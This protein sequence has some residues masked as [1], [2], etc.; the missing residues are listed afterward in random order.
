[1]VGK[2]QLLTETSEPEEE[3]F[4]AT[5]NITEGQSAEFCASSFIIHGG[6]THLLSRA[7]KKNGFNGSDYDPGFGI[8][9]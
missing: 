9:H 4:E 3:R 8:F 1:M 5:D 2:S 6:I 7:E